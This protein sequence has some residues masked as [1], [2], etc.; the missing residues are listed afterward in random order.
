MKQ[1][2]KV[3]VIVSG[4]VL[5]IIIGVLWGLKLPPFTIAGPPE[6]PPQPPPPQAQVIELE[7]TVASGTRSR[8]ILSD[9]SDDPLVIIQGPTPCSLQNLEVEVNAAHPDVLQDLRERDRVR[10][11]GSYI[12]EGIR[13]RVRV[14]SPGHYV[15]RVDVTPRIVLKGQ[16]KDF[17]PRRWL[18]LRLNSVQDVEEGPYPCSLDEVRVN[19]SDPRWN[20][21]SLSKGQWVRVE[22]LYDHNTCTITPNEIMKL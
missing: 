22:G 5:L 9:R 3:A 12:S 16:I 15:R 11:R 4:A 17:E 20:F 1:R 6:P 13:C 14:D 10:I 21:L 18:S 7:G 2:L 8:F 19:I